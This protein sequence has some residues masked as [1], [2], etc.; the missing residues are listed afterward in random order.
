MRGAAEDRFRNRC[1]NARV[2]GSYRKFST[3][4]RSPVS[5]SHWV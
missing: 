4:I 5:V 3:S 1:P 2:A